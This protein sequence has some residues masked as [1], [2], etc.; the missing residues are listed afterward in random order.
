MW[1]HY[2]ENH[3]GFCVEYDLSTIP[4]GHTFRRTLHP[5]IYSDMLYDSTPLVEKWIEGPQGTFNPFFPLLSFIHKAK[6]WSYEREWRLLFVSP[7]PE[8]NHAWSAPTPSR[9]FV[10][11]RMGELA[12]ERIKMFVTQKPIEI[13]QMRM[14]D[15]SF[16]LRSERVY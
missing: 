12:K 5:V 13:H 8:P 14:S 9:V 1:S 11:A 7:E 10:G 3:Q 2:A 4:E 16:V 15:D 6:E